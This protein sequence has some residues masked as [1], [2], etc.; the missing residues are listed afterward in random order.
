MQKIITIVVTRNRPFLLKK[1]ISA[2]LSQTRRPDS[3]Y[4]VD[5]DSQQPASDVLKDVNDKIIIIK[6]EHNVGCAGGFKT[7]IEKCFKN[8]QLNEDDFFWLMDDDSIPQEDALEKLTEEYF[9]T[10]K[11]IPISFCCSLVLYG[12]EIHKMNFPPIINYVN[13]IESITPLVKLSQK[14]LLVE[15]CSFVSVMV[16]LKHI[17]GAGLPLSDLFIWGDDVEFTRRISKK[18]GPGLFVLNSIVQHQTINNISTDIRD[19]VVENAWNKRYPQKLVGITTT[20]LYGSFSMY[21]GLK[22]WNKRKQ[23]SGSVMFEPTKETI[24][25]VRLWL[26]NHH[27]E[28]YYEWYFAKRP[29]GLP[30]K[31]EHKQ[32]SLQFSYRQLGID[33]KKAT[34]EHSRG[35]YFT[36]L[37][38]NTKE[39]LC[40]K[41]N[42]NELER[43]YDNRVSSLTDMWKMRYASKRVKSVM[44]KGSFRN[45]VL[46]YDEMMNMKTWSEVRGRYIGDVGG[47]RTGNQT[48]QDIAA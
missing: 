16:K 10:E 17:I 7:G 6:N 3:I 37:F 29:D 28:K 11:E 20:S 34:T 24:D 30:Y 38:T 13:N 9:H 35:V 39:F 43:R 32:R 41:I 40:K 42:E 2:I 26:K 15:S 4:V 45:D 25:M 31:R 8:K 48:E 33:L 14:S 5:N 22:Y 12:K 23:T 18:F 46:F 44:N 1:C 47:F 21:T 27:T 36:S 19:D